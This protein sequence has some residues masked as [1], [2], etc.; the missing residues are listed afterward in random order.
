MIPKFAAGPCLAEWT[1][2]EVFLPHE[3]IQAICSAF[4]GHDNLALV[5]TPQGAHGVVYIYFNDVERDCVRA[6]LSDL[7]TRLPLRRGRVLAGMIGID[8][9]WSSQ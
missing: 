1:T 4:E 8:A 9:A 6:I 3:S 2:W 7:E 5:R